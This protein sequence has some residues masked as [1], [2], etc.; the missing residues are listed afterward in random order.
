[1]DGA[2]GLWARVLEEKSHLTQRLKLADS[3]SAG[4]HRS[5]Q[6]PD[7]AGFAIVKDPDAHRRAMDISASYLRRGPQNGSNP[8]ELN[9]KQSRRA[10]VCERCGD[11]AAWPVGNSGPGDAARWGGA[12]PGRPA[13]IDPPPRDPEPG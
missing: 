6:I 13:G 12:Y 8:A 4:G 11:P 9:P 3:W 2:F 1:M 7:D 10:R 5:L